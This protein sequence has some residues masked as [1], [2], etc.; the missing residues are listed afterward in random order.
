MFREHY[1][2]PCKH[3]GTPLNTASTDRDIPRRIMKQTTQILD[4]L[5]EMRYGLLRKK[6]ANGTVHNPRAKA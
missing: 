4:E 1:L 6:T 3:D 5:Y 2:E